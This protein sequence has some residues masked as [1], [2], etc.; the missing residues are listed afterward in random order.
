MVNWHALLGRHSAD[1]RAS[2]W[3]K[4]RFVTDCLVCGCEMVKRP[5]GHWQLSSKP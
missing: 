5:A 3:D 4:G 2:R 1:L